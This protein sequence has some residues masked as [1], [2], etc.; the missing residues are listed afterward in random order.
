MKEWGK[1][2]GTQPG[3]EE[4]G[5]PGCKQLRHA[6]GPGSEEPPGVVIWQG[7]LQGR[8]RS[9]G[10][11]GYRFEEL[12]VVAAWQRKLQGTVFL[13][14]GCRTEEEQMWATWQCRLQGRVCSWGSA[15]CGLPGLLRR[16]SVCYSYWDRRTSL[17]I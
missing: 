4:H 16:Y 17:S 15:G 11:A 12:Q 14:A 9:W 5:I 8:V 13:G 1:V 10:A 2:L 3:A 7:M 6:K